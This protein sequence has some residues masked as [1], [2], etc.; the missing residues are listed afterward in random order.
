V[1]SLDEKSQ[2]G[3]HLLFL[4]G[5]LGLALIR[6]GVGDKINDKLPKALTITLCFLGGFLFDLV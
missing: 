4:S 5:Q 3:S 1:V 2:H 6:R